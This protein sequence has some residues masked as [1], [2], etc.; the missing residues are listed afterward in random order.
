MLHLETSVDLRKSVDANVT[1]IQCFV[2][3]R[4]A[5]KQYAIMIKVH[6]S[7]AKFQRIF[8]K[9]FERYHKVRVAS[10]CSFL[11]MNESY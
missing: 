10:M 5:K 4:A 6:K 3:G 11:K 2:R 1:V 7:I 9:R 8:R